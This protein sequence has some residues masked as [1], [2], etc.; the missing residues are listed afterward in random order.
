MSKKILVLLLTIL[1]LALPVQAAGSDVSA[2]DFLI[3]FGAMSASEVLEPD[4]PIT[5]GEFARL[6]GEI[7]V[8]YDADETSLE[9]KW[10]D[11]PRDS[12]YFNN[13]M[14]L[15]NLGI[16]NGVSPLEFAP[17]NNISST[18]ACAILVRILGYDFLAA[19]KGYVAQAG[20]IGLL[21]GVSNTT[22][23]LTAEN[24]YKML[25]NALFA[26][27]QFANVIDGHETNFHS[28]P[29][30]EKRFGISVVTGIVTDNGMTALAGETQIAE[31]DI[32]IGDRD[33]INNSGRNDLLGYTVS[34]YVK[35]D[36]DVETVIYMHPHK[37][38]NVV[39]EFASD[40]IK[41]FDSGIYS[42]YKSEN[43]E[44][45]DQYRLVGDYKFIYNG[46]YV[47]GGVTPE[48]LD[49]MMNP[50][51]GNV[52]LID[53]NSDRLYD[54]VIVEDYQT[55]VIRGY[56]N[57]SQTVYNALSVPTPVTFVDLQQSM[58]FEDTDKLEIFTSRGS[59]MNLDNLVK[60]NVISVMQ[61][62]DGEYAKIIVS[63]EKV[64][65]TLQGVEDNRY[66]KINSEVYE[67]AS[68]L[69]TYIDIPAV[70]NNITLYMRHDGKVAFIE[71]SNELNGVYA[72]LHRVYYDEFE[73]K[74]RVNIFTENKKVVKA[75]FANRPVIDG[76]KQASPE[77]AMDYIL[78]QP[79][80][81]N[82]LVVVKLNETDEIVNMD[83]AFYAYGESGPVAAGANEGDKSL[84][85][86]RDKYQSNS[87]PISWISSS[88]YVDENTKIFVVPFSMTE[89]ITSIEQVDSSKV[90]L[91]EINVTTKSNAAVSDTTSVHTRY[92][93]DEDSLYTDAIIVYR[94]TTGK[95][96]YKT[97]DATRANNV[98]VTEIN[99][100][101]NVNNE[102]GW[103]IW[104]TLGDDPKRVFTKTLN[105]NKCAKSGNAIQVGDII[106][107]STDKSGI[108]PDNQLII[109]YSPNTDADNLIYE[110]GSFSDLSYTSKNI[111]QW[112]FVL[113][114]GQVDVMNDRFARIIRTKYT[115]GVPSQEE[116]LLDRSK[117]QY[118]VYKDGRVEL[119][120]STYIETVKD[121]GP[122]ASD[123]IFNWTEGAITYAYI[124]Q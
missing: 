124:V 25:R 50:K 106:K 2:T 32:K 94:N 110:D 46:K 81:L 89:D 56:Q 77:A 104:Y 86:M 4:S 49:Q 13:V 90:D 71:D 74:V 92:T 108:I 76:I 96:M 27:V 59:K 80:A 58:S 101:I 85:I 53:N 72:Y 68:D 21:D 1:A 5:R 12:K 38:K 33:F 79:Y 36:S 113:L 117:M 57:V 22:D 40:K 43:T 11:V 109:M 115:S 60:Y 8:S 9:Q 3:G 70:G 65:G 78:A 44:K 55:I 73:E 82:G 69:L 61:S 24:A 7:A 51:F 114:K 10:A 87:S 54:V 31:N 18:D 19:E 16:I 48:L 111:G 29:L 88:G 98:I 15:T 95:D 93:L 28:A 91:E 119:A 116:I 14:L 41:N 118:V 17:D 45:T 75:T 35:K 42:V 23:Y 83:T 122:G 84:Q 99:Q 120:D 20:E 64:S 121:I 100:G 112:E 30:M 62:A 63:T 97:T 102:V 105:G 67:V 37:Q 26:E 52:T 34:A 66:L 107:F 39:A 6:A 103:E 123:V 47:G